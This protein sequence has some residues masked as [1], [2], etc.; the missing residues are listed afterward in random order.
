LALKGS[1]KNN[2]KTKTK[3]TINMADQCKSGGSGDSLDSPGESPAQPAGEEEKNSQYLKTVDGLFQLK[4]IARDLFHLLPKGVD[5]PCVGK[6][7]SA[8]YRGDLVEEVVDGLERNIRDHNSPGVYVQGPEGAGKSILAPLH[9]DSLRSRNS[10]SIG[11]PCT[12]PTAS[13]GLK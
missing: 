9:S 8:V 12:F 10:S 2:I 13:I 1:K 3:K 7:A 5:T 11:L 6:S 4:P